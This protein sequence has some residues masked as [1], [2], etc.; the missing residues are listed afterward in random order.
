MS[1]DTSFAKLDEELSLFLHD[2]YPALFRNTVFQVLAIAAAALGV[3]LW[4]R[5]RLLE[6]P[7]PTHRESADKKYHSL[8][9]ALLLVLLAIQWQKKDLQGG[10]LLLIL[11][12]LVCGAAIYALLSWRQIGV[13]LAIAALWL[14]LPMKDIPLMVAARADWVDIAQY[15]LPGK[16]GVFATGKF[17]CG[18]MVVLSLFAGILSVV[19]VA[20]YTYR[21]YL[22][23]ETAA[24]FF[25]GVSACPKCGRILTGEGKYCAACGTN[26]EGLPRS[27]FIWEEEEDPVY[28]PNCG[29]AMRNRDFCVGCGFG[30]KI[31]EIVK[32]EAKDAVKEQVV[33]YVV[34]GLI[35]LIVFVPIFLGNVTKFL[36]GGRAEVSNAFTEKFDQWYQDEN[37]ADDAAWLAD[38][39]AS[40]QA[41]F[42]FNSK[43]FRVMPERLSYNNLYIYIQYLDASYYQM[44]VQQQI[45][46]AVH[47][48]DGSEK[49]ALGDYFNGTL[50]LQT[51]ALGSGLSMMSSGGVSGT[52]RVLEN[53]AA[54][55]L[56][57]CLSYVPMWLR[58]ILLPGTAVFG[59]WRWLTLRKKKPSLNP[60]KT[61]AGELEDQE[62][63]DKL[64]KAGA[65]A[66][67]KDRMY[68]AIGIG[69][70]V[71]FMAVGFAK[72]IRMANEKTY[73][74][75]TAMNE[76]FTV[77]GPALVLWFNECAS[78]PETALGEKEEAQSLLESCCLALEFVTQAEPP[79]SLE[80]ETAA[81]ATET[82]AALKEALEIMQQRL[83]EGQ[84]P[85]K[86]EI[87]RASALFKTGM[88]LDSVL[89]YH[90]TM[91]QLSEMF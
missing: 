26:V 14:T 25:T 45:S 21:R 87:S 70:V 49:Q 19:I 85:G 71:I 24:Q 57:F 7:A 60:L 53:A 42:D 33:K 30:K 55:G 3:G 36:A 84:L 43:G 66:R 31:G 20:Y 78:D 37:L 27:E 54:D 89:I 28:C 59:L 82:A 67:K 77:N 64:R 76:A 72:D 73:T 79:E 69:I 48:K 83:A 47:A 17:V 32:D 38:F 50:D 56:R 90:N 81:A 63:L 74:Y 61:A 10:M 12:V 22:F 39:D 65:A 68:A 46:A 52:L 80:A 13:T 40:N 23:R 88:N 4:L 18:R 41:L 35:A 86:E 62:A 16:I 8:L 75:Q 1:I 5:M 2:A 15:S 91:E 29:R 34:L 11:S 58:Y 51:Q 44:T 6:K 9:P